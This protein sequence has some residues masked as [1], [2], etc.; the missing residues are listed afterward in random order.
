MPILKITAIDNQ[1]P[2]Y[3]GL[4]SETRYNSEK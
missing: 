4:V 3:R 2:S 1:I